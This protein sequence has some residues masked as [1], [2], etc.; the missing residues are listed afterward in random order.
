MNRLS[1]KVAV[2]TGGARGMGAAT[3]RLFAQ[4]GARVVIADLLEKEGR[5]LAEEIGEAALFIRL[6]VSDEVQWKKL[7]DETLA[8]WGR[9]DVLVNNAGIVMAKSIVDTTKEEFER[10]LSINATGTF[11]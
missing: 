9:I 4:E 10:V 11:L 3:A 8:R 2:V 7:V 5:A 6:D 1:N